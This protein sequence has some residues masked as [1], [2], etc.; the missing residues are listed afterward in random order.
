MEKCEICTPT[1]TKLKVVK[2][3]K[4]KKGIVRGDKTGREGEVYMACI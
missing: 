1:D 3:K 4:S 2:K